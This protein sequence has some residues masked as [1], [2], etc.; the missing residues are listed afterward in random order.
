M[1]IDF[2]WNAH[3]SW[4]LG[5]ATPRSYSNF[6]FTHLESRTPKL[7]PNSHWFVL[8]WNDKRKFRLPQQHHRPHMSW[9]AISCAGHDHTWT[10]Y[11]PFASSQSFSISLHWHQCIRT[12]IRTQ[13]A[14]AMQ[15]IYRYCDLCSLNQVTTPSWYLKLDLY[16]FAVWCVDIQYTPCTLQLSFSIYTRFMTLKAKRKGTHLEERKEEKKNI[17]FFVRST[18]VH[19]PRQRSKYTRFVSGTGFYFVWREF[20]T[21]MHAMCCPQYLYKC[22]FALFDCVAWT[23]V[24]VCDWRMRIWFCDRK[25]AHPHRTLAPVG[26]M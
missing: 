11:L 26:V 8:K 2:K 23:L 20:A 6:L 9:W 7:G 10:M 5:I 12:E 14:R 22:V 25:I 16:G 13:E 17:R 1:S 15:N 3:R 21:K 19:G 18:V 4:A 24:C